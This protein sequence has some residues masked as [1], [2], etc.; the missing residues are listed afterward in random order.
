MGALVSQRR[1]RPS[2]RS[3]FFPEAEVLRTMSEQQVEQQASATAQRVVAELKEKAVALDQRGQQIAEERKALAYGALAE[4]DAKSVKALAQLA[5]EAA[6]VGSDMEALA[7]ALEE[8]ERRLAIANA[9][10]VRLEDRGNALAARAVLAEFLEAATSLDEALT[11]IGE[12]A[13]ALFAAVRKLH[14]LG[15]THPS[16]EQVRVLGLAAVQTALMSTPWHK[17]FPFLAP[18]DRRSW[19]S[20]ARTWSANI[21]ANVA[22]TLGEGEAAWSAP[23]KTTESADAAA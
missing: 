2:V 13:V 12:E 23:D 3:A 22:S 4:K 9:A 20:L 10:E 11:A 1:G 15:V 5:L 8:A 19:S 7:A 16:D 21:E 17:A 18:R 6:K 14:A